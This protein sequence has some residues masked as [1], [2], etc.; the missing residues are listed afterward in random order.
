MKTLSEI[1][2]ILLV[3]L[4][5]V[6]GTAVVFSWSAP[7][8]IGWTTQATVVSTHDGDTI[9]IRFYREFNCRIRG[10]WAKE[11]KETGGPEARDYM[12]QLVDGKAVT[13]HVP[14]NI[15]LGKMTTMS[16]IVAD[17]YVGDESVAAKMIEAGHATAEKQR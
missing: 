11:L 9:K 4:A 8:P 10:C 13:V 17:V 2:L 3:M 7:P 1:N 15:D 6:L 16:R 12:K 14:G 5:V